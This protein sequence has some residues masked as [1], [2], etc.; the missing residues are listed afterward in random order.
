MSLLLPLTVE[1]LATA[2][3][4]QV[5]SDRIRFGKQLMARSQSPGC[6]PT[7]KQAAFADQCVKLLGNGKQAAV[8]AGYS[9]RSAAEVAYEN[10]NKPHVNAAVARQRQRVAARLEMSAA[11]VSN[12]ISE[13]SARGRCS[14]L[15]RRPSWTGAVA[16]IPRHVRRHVAASRCQGGSGLVLSPSPKDEVYFARPLPMCL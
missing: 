2:Q 1:P 14:R 7:V 12:E 13:V 4:G 15:R 16:Q 10:L 3:L 11:R 6:K 8:A 5:G 9:E